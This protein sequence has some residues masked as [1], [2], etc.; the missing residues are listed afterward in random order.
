MASNDD[1]TRVLGRLEEKVEQLRADFSDEKHT[2]HE[3]R[4][5]IHQRLDQQ[6]RQ[7]AVL[8]KAVAI[9]AEIYAQLRDR[10]EALTGTVKDNHGAV[11][12]TI[13]DMKR[14]KT[15]GYGIA[16]LIAL[17]GLSVGGLRLWAGEAAVA[18]GRHWLRI[19]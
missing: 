16:G 1:I 11:A 5:I 14:L 18:T 10:I 15:L 2:A 7:L 19:P 12:P 17:A 9:H 8:D 3:S 13:E 6:V 4:A